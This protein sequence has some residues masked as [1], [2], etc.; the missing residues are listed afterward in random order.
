MITAKGYRF[1]F[2]L[3]AFIFKSEEDRLFCGSSQICGLS[4]ADVI[5]NITKKLV[6]LL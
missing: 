5:K 6:N 1:L 3:N 4:W 2:L